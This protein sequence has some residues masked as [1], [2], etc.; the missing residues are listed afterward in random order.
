MIDK[1]IPQEEMKQ[2]MLDI[3]QEIHAFCENNGL[4]YYLAF[5]T[6]IGAIRHKGF[7]PWDDDIDL[8]MPRPDYERFMKE[9]RHPYMQVLSM[10][11]DPNYP[12][13]FM[14]VH[15]CRTIVKEEGG[16]GNWGIFVDIF[17]FEGI[18]NEKV[19]RKRFKKVVA[20]RH[21]IANQRFTWKYKISEGHNL[22]KKAA[23]FFGKCLHPFIQ[24]NSLLRW[25]D[26][27][28]KKYD[29]NQCDFMCDYTAVPSK[30]PP[31]F[32]PKEKILDRILMDFE[33]RQFYGPK[34]Y[35][36][37]LKHLYGDYMKLPPKEK[38]VS[39]HGSIAYW[40]S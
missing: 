40:K 15:D 17:P 7:I 9:F 13:E 16:D 35:D 19:W 12:L 25:Q 39:L 33:G 27:T 38:Q 4:R 29:F 2:M 34:E 18:P 36:F 21:L 11:T 5:G 6:M 14:K 32:A 30:Y 8:W 26:R 20:I 10:Y 31:L 23:I 22:S 1:V 37:F 3:L 28:I 24:L